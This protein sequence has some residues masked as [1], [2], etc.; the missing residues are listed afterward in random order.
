MATSN[1]RKCA[2]LSPTNLICGYKAERRSVCL[3]NNTKISSPPSPFLQGI[4]APWPTPFRMLTANLIIAYSSPLF[5]LFFSTNHG[6]VN[7]K[8]LLF[9]GAGRDGWLVSA[10]LTAPRLRVWSL[11]GPLWAMPSLGKKTTLLFFWYF[12]FVGSSSMD[13]GGGGDKILP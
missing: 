1:Q 6:L 5:S 12:S 2:Y 10:M 9:G 3:R 8:L 7:Q 11:Q 4:N 13:L